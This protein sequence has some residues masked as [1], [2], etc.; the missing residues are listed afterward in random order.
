MEILNINLCL[1]ILIDAF[2][3]LFCGVNCW[4]ENLKFGKKKTN[5][6]K[7]KEIILGLL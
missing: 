6:N 3:F 2:F 4:R 5:E 1:K 7:D